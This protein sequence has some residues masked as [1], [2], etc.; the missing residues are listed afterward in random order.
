MGVPKG[1]NAIGSKWVY[2][3]NFKSNGDVE[4]YKARLVT[5]GYNQ[6]E[7]LDYHET[8]SPVGKMV[9]VRTLIALAA[10]RGWNMYQMD[11]FNAFL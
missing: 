2:K 6:K 8:S 1:K 7:G 3:I 10:S 9:T 5:K 4:R 11:V